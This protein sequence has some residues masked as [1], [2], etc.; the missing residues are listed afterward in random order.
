MIPE[1]KFLP[2]PTTEK[3][4]DFSKDYIARHGIPKVIRTDPATTLRSKRFKEFCQKRL[5]KHI[6]CPVRDQRGIGEIERLIRTIIERLRTNKNIIVTRDNSGLSEILFALRMYFSA[7]GNSAYEKFTEQEPNTIKKLVTESFRCIS[8]SPTVELTDMDFES[9]QDSAILVRERTRGTKLEGA[10]KKR[11]GPLLEH[12]THTIT[13]FP[14]GSNQPT[15]IS[16]TVVGKI[17]S[18]ADKPC[19][20][21]ELHDWKKLSNTAS[22]HFQANSHAAINKHKKMKAQLRQQTPTRQNC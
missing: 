20:S 2:K 6:E 16:K 11:R 8:D 17:N 4:V 15:I 5:I 1:S 3:V 12:S 10:F 9:G 21:R 13:F 22:R 7:T 18:K 14:A 19:C